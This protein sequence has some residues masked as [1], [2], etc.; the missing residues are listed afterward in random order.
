MQVPVDN[1]ASALRWTLTNDNFPDNV[2]RR[3]LRHF[4]ITTL[5]PKSEFNKPIGRVNETQEFFATDEDD[6]HR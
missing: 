1:L 5:G 2:A 4:S 3:V 6:E